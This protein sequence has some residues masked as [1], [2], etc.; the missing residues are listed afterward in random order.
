M[1]LLD[2]AIK[3]GIAP[4]IV[5]AIYLI[6]TKIIDSR[7]E[8]V[9]LK[10]NSELT[11]SVNTISAFIVNITKDVID[12]DKD[13]CKAAIEESIYSSGARL[14]QFVTNTLINNHIEQNK[15][16]ILIN[17]HNIVHAEYY[18]VYS[19]LSLYKFE[20]KY[21]SESLNKKW[22]EDVEKDIIDVIY[23]NK[24]SKEDKIMSFINK[25]NI[26]FQSYIIYIINNNIH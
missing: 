6:I 22:K 4:A 26:K 7:K 25:I 23:N 3:E 20:N 18:M 2:E 19:T 14:I 10:L 9:Q 24:L 21:V 8:N 5:V 15:N 13:K 16:T 17:I 11:K 12:K 1:E